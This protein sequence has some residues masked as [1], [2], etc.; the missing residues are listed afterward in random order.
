MDIIIV[1]NTNGFIRINKIIYKYSLS[2]LAQARP[3]KSLL[4]L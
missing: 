2:N 3:C 1:S 4:L